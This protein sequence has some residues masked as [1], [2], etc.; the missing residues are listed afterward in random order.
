M[1]AYIAL[2]ANLGDRLGTLSRAVE[3]IGR[4]SCFQI[5]S[6][7]SIYD[8]APVGPPQPRYLNAVLRVTAFLGAAATLKKLHAIEETLGRI[9]R[10]KWGPREIDLDL[11]LFGSQ[12]IE[13]PIA[14]PHPRLHQRAFVLLPLCEVNADVRHPGLQQSARELLTLLPQA[15]RDGVRKLGPLRRRDFADEDTDAAPSDAPTPAAT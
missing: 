4:E 15:D 13:G 6:V 11:L 9:R 8:T 1:D 2:G 14:V 5:R 10:E 3:L 7:S 12:V